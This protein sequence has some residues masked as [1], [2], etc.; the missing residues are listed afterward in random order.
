M[1]ILKAFDSRSDWDANQRYRS[2]LPPINY[3]IRTNYDYLG[4]RFDK[5]Y[6][7]DDVLR[8]LIDHGASVT[9][10]TD[11]G[12]TLM[13]FALDTDNQYLQA[14]LVGKGVNLMHQDDSGR[15]DL[16]RMIESGSLATLEEAYRN[17]MV[18]INVHTV[19]N[20]AK[21]MARHKDLYDFVT[22]VCADQ[23]KT[24]DDMCTFRSRYADKVSLV[25]EKYESMAR[26]EVAKASDY[27]AISACISRYPDL[28]YITG[29]KKR[30]I[31]EKE[32]RTVQ[33]FYDYDVFKQHY[34]EYAD[35]IKNSRD[36]IAAIE[37]GSV[38][39]ISDIKSFEQHYPELKDQISKKRED[40]YVRDCQ[41]VQSIYSSALQNLQNRRLDASSLSDVNSFL[42]GYEG[43]FDP[44]EVVPKAK[45]LKRHLMCVDVAARDF[46]PYYNPDNEFKDRYYSDMNSLGNAIRDA[47]SGAEYQLASEWLESQLERKKSIITDHYN[48]CLEAVEKVNQ[49]SYRDLV[50]PSRIFRD[51]KNTTYYFDGFS[52]VVTDYSNEAYLHY[53][54]HLMKGGKLSGFV[55]GYG[56][57]EDAVTAGYG[58]GTYGFARTEGPPQ[59]LGGLLSSAISLQRMKLDIYNA[60]ESDELDGIIESWLKP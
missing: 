27:G 56:S 57:M 59:T 2:E 48:A 19:K 21:D 13:T 44:D 58:A 46:K 1:K 7:A 40:I 15:D 49:I 8:I 39:S 9:S 11:Q 36:I 5:D 52:F 45:A 10:Y 51:G 28:N 33:S 3:L 30:Q 43:Y 12:Q 41:M 53:V 37:L 55:K 16:Y 25:K 47:Q 31:A 4:H 32:S 50:R 14:Y 20:D 26:E 38:S 29:P 23:V 54:V 24:Y 18:T 17:G 42:E 6:I 34:P 35:L 60:K 22:R